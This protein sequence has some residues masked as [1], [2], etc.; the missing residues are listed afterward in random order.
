MKKQPR[1]KNY[2]PKKTIKVN[3]N[4][5]LKQRKTKRKTFRISSKPKKINK[6]ISQTKSNKLNSKSLKQIKI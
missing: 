2:K 6:R 5:S 3:Y 1:I 4:K